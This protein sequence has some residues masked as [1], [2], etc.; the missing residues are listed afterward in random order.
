MGFVGR[1]VGRAV[2]RGLGSLA[3]NALGKVTGIGS[4]RGGDIGEEIGGDLLSKLI[5][6]KKGG[7]VKRTGPILAHKGEYVLP[8]GVKPTKTQLK[9]VAK[10]RSKKRMTKHK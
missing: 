5:P 7:K 4:R 1:T 10:K 8:V 2:G 9:K 3:G 6:F